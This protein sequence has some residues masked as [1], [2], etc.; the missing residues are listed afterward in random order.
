MNPGQYTVGFLKIL[1]GALAIAGSP[2]AT[3]HRLPKG[4]RPV[5]QPAGGNLQAL[6]HLHHH[7]QT[8]AVPTP[9]ALI[10][11]DQTRKSAVLA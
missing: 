11:Q 2:F 7:L 10:D 4:D 5:S 9:A 3:N 6:L 1:A 8:D